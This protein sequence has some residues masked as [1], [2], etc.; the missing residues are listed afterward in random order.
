MEGKVGGIQ[1]GEVRQYAGRAGRGKLMGGFRV[2]LDLDTA[3][4]LRDFGINRGCT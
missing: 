4:W 3:D 1:Y 2:R